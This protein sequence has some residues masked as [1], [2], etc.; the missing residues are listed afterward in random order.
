MKLFTIGDSISQ[1]FVSGMAARTEL[2]YS[3][4]IADVLGVSPYPIPSFPEGGLFADIEGIARAMQRVAGND[5]DLWNPIELGRALW[6]AA[7][8]LDASEDY[9]ERGDG[10]ID[11][12][13]GDGQHFYPNVSCYGFT[14]ADTWLVNDAICREA[15]G[16]EDEPARDNRVGI[17]SAPFYR[18]AQ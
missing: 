9:Y 14:I 13:N 10:G 11:R 4:R 7:Q 17:A 5:L 2:S 16:R 12:A 15:I 6:A 1:G 3:K 8:V 18:N